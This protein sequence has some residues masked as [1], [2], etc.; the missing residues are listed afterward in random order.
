MYAVSI[1]CLVSL[2]WAPDFDYCASQGKHYF[3]YKL[4]VLC[5]LSGVIH[6]YDPPKANVYD[7]NYMKDIKPLYHDCCIFGD[8]G[9]SVRKSNLTFSRRSISDLNAPTGSTKRTGGQPSSLSQ[10][11]ERELKLC[12]RNLLI[13]SS[14]SGTTQRK[15]ADFLPE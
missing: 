4:H 10:R 8:K 3:G 15:P 2:I 9:Y 6:S 1:L 7:I 11:H 12:F 14:S 5:G 13:S